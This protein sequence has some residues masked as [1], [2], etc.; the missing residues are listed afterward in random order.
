MILGQRINSR[1]LGNSFNDHARNLEHAGNVQDVSVLYF[2]MVQ[3]TISVRTAF[4]QT[5]LVQD[6]FFQNIF[7]FMVSDEKQAFLRVD[8]ISNTAVCQRIKFGS[9]VGFGFSV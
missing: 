2:H 1:I 9:C 4:I 3:K 5:K 6:N 7:I 8:V